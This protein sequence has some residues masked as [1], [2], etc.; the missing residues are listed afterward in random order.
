MTQNE[1]SS[2]KHLK[3]I[4]DREKTLPRKIMEIVKAELYKE[5]PTTDR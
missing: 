2:M 4:W 3:E 1:D 5:I